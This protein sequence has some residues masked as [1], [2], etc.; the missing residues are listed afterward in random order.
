MMRS[1]LRR[2]FYLEPLWGVT[3]LLSGGVCLGCFWE[4]CVLGCLRDF[5]DLFGKGFLCLSLLI[6][7][8]QSKGGRNCLLSGAPFFP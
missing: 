4:T 2:D 3:S 8:C 6:R 7:V 1:F 5:W